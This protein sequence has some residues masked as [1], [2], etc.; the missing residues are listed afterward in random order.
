MHTV[1]LQIEM[2]IM[3]SDRPGPASPQ[4]LLASPNLPSCSEAHAN[5]C[6]IIALGGM[7]AAQHYCYDYAGGK[8]VFFA[9]VAGLPTLGCAALH[10]ALA[11]PC[12]PTESA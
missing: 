9:G 3:R 10:I 7:T 12:S 8:T 11:Y 6:R 2:H 5:N 4:P 1:K